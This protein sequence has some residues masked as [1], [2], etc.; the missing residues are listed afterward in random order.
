MKNT[1]MNE[2][3]RTMRSNLFLQWKQKNGRKC[4]I[5]FPSA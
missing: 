1:Q 5:F 3:G 2:R 4:D